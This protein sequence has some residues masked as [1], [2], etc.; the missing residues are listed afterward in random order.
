MSGERY[1]THPSNDVLP[2]HLICLKTYSCS[3]N[4]MII[5]HSMHM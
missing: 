5:H 4:E 3:L 1:F 2:R